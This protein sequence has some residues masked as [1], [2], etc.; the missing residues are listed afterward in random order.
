MKKLPLFSF[1]AASLFSACGGTTCDRLNASNDK[2]FAGQTT[3]K[4]TSGSSNVTVTRGT[5]CADTSKCSAEDVK[6]LETYS[7]CIGNAQVC[8]AG[9][10]AKATSDAM[11]CALAAGLKL[12]AD[13][14]AVLK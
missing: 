5:A 11:A 8:T 10:E 13:C 6:T 4:S 7:T 3:C 9:N 14:A 1:L 12:S 2:F